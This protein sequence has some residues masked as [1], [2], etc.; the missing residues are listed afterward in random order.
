MQTGK[1]AA[2]G[3]E[4]GQRMIFT[5]TVRTKDGGGHCHAN[6]GGSEFRVRLEHATRGTFS[7]HVFFYFFFC[8][9]GKVADLSLKCTLYFH[10]F[11]LVFLFVFLRGI[12]M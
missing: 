2:G 3:R 8:R 11:V 10:L 5:G 6:G 12:R 9:I 1:A 7:T 4:P